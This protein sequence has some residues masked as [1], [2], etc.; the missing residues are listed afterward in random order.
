M[1]LQFYAFVCII[2]F[3]PHKTLLVRDVR[4]IIPTLQMCKLRVREVN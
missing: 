4:Q 2:L 3:E 1:I